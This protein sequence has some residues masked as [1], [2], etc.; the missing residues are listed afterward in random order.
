MIKE[1][2]PKNVY[3]LIRTNQLFKSFQGDQLI[4][5]ID[6]IIYSDIWICERNN[7]DNRHVFQLEDVV[8]S[9]VEGVWIPLVEIPEHLDCVKCNFRHEYVQ[10][11][12]ANEIFI[13]YK[14]RSGF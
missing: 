4:W 3:D 13:C 11:D 2:Y 9:F 14:C 8:G 7:T 1:Y 10:P 6:D 12:E 5:K